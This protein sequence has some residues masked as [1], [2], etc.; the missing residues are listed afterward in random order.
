MQVCRENFPDR[1]AST[2][3]LMC[4]VCLRNKKEVSWQECMS[5]RRET[6]QEDRERANRARNLGFI[7]TVAGRKLEVTH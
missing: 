4:L 7:P 5:K 6:I 2:K 3:A 1:T